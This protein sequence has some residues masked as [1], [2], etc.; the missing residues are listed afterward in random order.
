MH[1]CIHLTFVSYDHKSSK[2][3]DHV[4]IWSFDEF[5]SLCLRFLT[6]K[7]ISHLTIVCYHQNMIRRTLGLTISP[8][9]MM[10]NLGYLGEKKI[11]SSNQSWINQSIFNRKQWIMKIAHHI[12]MVTSHV[13]ENITY[14]L[15]Q[16]DMHEGLL[17][18]RYFFPFGNIKRN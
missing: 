3:L 8:F 7:P 12:Y 6:I 9:F 13:H 2:S 17:D 4:S 10:S 1:P 11:S 14:M 5:L 18:P 15:I 16:I